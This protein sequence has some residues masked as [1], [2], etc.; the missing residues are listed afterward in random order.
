MS[1]YLWGIGQLVNDPSAHLIDAI[2]KHILKK[3]APTVTNEDGSNNPCAKPSCSFTKTSS[4]N[5]DG[6]KKT[7]CGLS[8]VPNSSKLTEPKTKSTVTQVGNGPVKRRH[9]STQCQ[10]LSKKLNQTTS[11]ER[12]DYFDCSTI[13]SNTNME[14][15]QEMK[16][17]ETNTMKYNFCTQHQK[18]LETLSDCSAIK[19]LRYNK[20]VKLDILAKLK[21]RISDAFS[22]FSL[23]KIE[24]VPRYKADEKYF[25]KLYSSLS[26]ENMQGESLHQV[27]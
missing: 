3:H 27:R 21:S 11:T 12:V 2:Q 15:K 5:L 16:N 8:A 1:G 4:R 25:F 23:E 18:A 22:F 14:K 26:L 20:K 13:V 7:G 10:R 24:N 6:K 19:R 9:V 17:A